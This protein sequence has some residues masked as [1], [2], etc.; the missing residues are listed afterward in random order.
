MRRDFAQ[1]VIRSVKE[2]GVFFVC[3]PLDLRFPREPSCG[4][5]NNGDLLLNT[6]FYVFEGG[7]GMRKF[8]RHVGPG[9]VKIAGIVDVDSPRDLVPPIKCDPLDGLTHLPITYQENIHAA[10]FCR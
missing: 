1:T 8:D 3:E 10:I 2:R 7:I 6:F 4:A 5:A 9:V